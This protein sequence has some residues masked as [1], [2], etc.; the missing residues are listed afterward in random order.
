V[1]RE[2]KDFMAT[3]LMVLSALVLIAVVAF[4]VAKLVAQV[5]APQEGVAGMDPMKL[6]AIER[7]IAP[8]GTVVTT[9]AEVVQAVAAAP[10]SAQDIVE[11]LCNSCHLAGVLGAPVV[12][13]K[14]QWEARLAE[15]WDRLVHAAVNGVGSMP[16]KGGDPSL[17]EE[18]IAEAIAY[19]LEESGL[20]APTAAAEPEAGPATEPETAEASPPA[21]ESAEEGTVVEASVEAEATAAVDPA[22]LARGESVYGNACMACH[23]VGVLGAPKLGDQAAWSSRLAQGVD[24]LYANAINGK[25]GM[26]AKGGRL[27]LS[28]ADVRAAVDYM[29]DATR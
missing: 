15:G 7:R 18:Q 21:A 19:M 12:G 20:E 2:D 1:N 14:A 16:A 4:L 28:D 24:A 5:P 27:D 10:R 29:L 17:T 6:D 25:G 22:V 8:V 23:M 11:G 26:P 3:F 13:N 9:G